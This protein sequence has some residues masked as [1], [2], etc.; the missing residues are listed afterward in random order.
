MT[1]I[2]NMRAFWLRVTPDYDKTSMGRALATILELLVDNHGCQ[3]M[4]KHQGKVVCANLLVFTHDCYRHFFE[5][6]NQPDLVR[7]RLAG[8]A[9]DPT[10]WA[11]YEEQ[12]RQQLIPL[13]M[14]I[15]GMRPGEFGTVPHF[16]ALL[17]PREYFTQREYFNQPPAKRQALGTH[18]FPP[19]SGPPDFGS[20]KPPPRDINRDNNH[21][22]DKGFLIWKKNARLPLCP[23]YVPTKDGKSKERLCLFYACRSQTCRT[24]QCAQ[25]HVPRFDVLPMEAQKSL[26][27]FVQ[28]TDGLDFVPHSGPQGKPAD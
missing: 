25:I 13:Q 2:M 11:A 27:A 23:V 20:T 21:G 3:W 9:I 16:L 14:A 22:N 6:A 24:R 17:W 28:K 15:H 19:K 7:A 10:N 1:A 8:T 18:P 4:E 12:A 5:Q 26:I